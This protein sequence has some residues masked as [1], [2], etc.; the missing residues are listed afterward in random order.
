[1]FVCSLGP[2][3]I[4][5]NSLKDIGKLLYFTLGIIDVL[6]TTPYCIINPL[7]NTLKPNNYIRIRMRH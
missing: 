5:N 6:G 1:M 3:T 7:L 2:I 4:V